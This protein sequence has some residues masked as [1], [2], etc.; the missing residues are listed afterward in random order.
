[1]ARAYAA[2]G[3]G[4]IME[5]FLPLV[6]HRLVPTPPKR[7]NK[8]TIKNHQARLTHASV[9]TGI[10]LANCTT[11]ISFQLGKRIAEHAGISPGQAMAILLT[12]VL[13][14]MAD[15]RSDLGNLLHPLAG[16]EEFSRVPPSQ[17]PGLSIH[18]IQHLLNELHQISLGTLP[19]TLGDAGL[20]PATIEGLA[21]TILSDPA[22]PG[23]QIPGIDPKQIQAIL[24]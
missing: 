15:K 5:N 22:L 9:L 10:L 13:D 14:H 12:A 23:S 21:Q 3:I 2:T 4:L 1:M 6:K 7:S 20:D 24:A 19:R 17:R 11:L 18:K 16:P 8:K